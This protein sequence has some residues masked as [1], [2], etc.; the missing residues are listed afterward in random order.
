[1]C[2]ASSATI[3]WLEAQQETKLEK[4]VKILKQL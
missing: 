4:L 3:Y 2:R 1:M